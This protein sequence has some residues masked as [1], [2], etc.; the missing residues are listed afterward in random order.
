M[1]VAQSSELHRRRK[2]KQFQL[3]IPALL[4]VHAIQIHI[5]EA[6]S[7][8]VS[9]EQVLQFQLVLSPSLLLLLDTMPL[10][11]TMSTLKLLLTSKISHHSVGSFLIII[12]QLIPPSTNTKHLKSSLL[13]LFRLISMSSSL[14][15][16]WT[17]KKTIHVLLLNTAH[18]QHTQVPLLLVDLFLEMSFISTMMTISMARLCLVQKTL[19]SPSQAVLL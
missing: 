16:P 12:R 13:T 10:Q 14:L 18:A 7:T 2:V 6:S 1:K 9:Q 19:L 11:E 15:T 3:I 5:S 17:R 8:S 4:D